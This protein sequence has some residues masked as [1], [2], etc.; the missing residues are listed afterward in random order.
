MSIVVCLMGPVASGKSFISNQLRDTGKFV[1]VSIGV[2]CRDAE[3]LSISNSTRL[4]AKA[5]FRSGEL[6]TAEEIDELIRA[7]LSKVS[8]TSVCLDGFPRVAD[9]VRLLSDLSRDLG[10]IEVIGVNCSP[11]REICE[12]RFL[13]R[14][15]PEQLERGFEFYWSRYQ[16]AELEA[17]KAFGDCYSLT[18][19]RG[20][21]EAQATISAIIDQ[22]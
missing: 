15:R 18:T 17:I 2:L 7:F 6:I 20:D 21:E 5:A 3:T 10:I 9:S 4:R 11:T 8:N 13:S 19:V 22:L 14:K 1:S 16:N 12:A